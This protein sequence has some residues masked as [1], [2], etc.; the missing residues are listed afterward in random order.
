M[1]RFALGHLTVA[2]LLPLTAGRAPFLA[3][4]GDGLGEAGH[5]GQSGTRGE[6]VERRRERR[7][8]AYVGQH[9]AELV[10]HRPTA[11]RA[12]PVQRVHRP[13][14]GGTDLIVDLKHNPKGI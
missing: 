3:P 14:A 1:P 13:L 10:G 2:T 9:G 12:H 6:G 8:G 5:R 7:P 4:F 11:A